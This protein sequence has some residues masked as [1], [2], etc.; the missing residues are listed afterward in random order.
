[1]ASL[2][3][4]ADALARVLDGVEP[5][6]SVDAPLT[7]AEGRVLAADVAALR[8]QPP[9]DMSAMDGY[10]ARA[11]DLTSVPIT[12]KVA[13]EVAAGHPFRGELRPGEVARIFTGGVVPP[14]ADTIVI[15]ENTSRDGDRVTVRQ[16]EKSGRHIRRAGLDFKEGQVLLPRGRRLT[17]R[18]VM[19]AAGMSH[20]ALPVHRRPKVA[21]FATGDELKAP[22]ST[23]G[24]GE[25][26][27]SNGFG[28][29]ALARNEGVEVIDLGIVPDDVEATVAAIRR[30]RQANVDVLVTTG[31]ASVGDHDLVQRGL[32]AEGLELSFWRVA[33]RPG[34][35]IMH[36]RLGGMHVLGMPG[37][38]VSAYV[39]SFLFLVPLV[40][41][42]SG[43]SDLSAVPDSAV[44]GVDMPE[45]DERADYMRATL[46]PSSTGTPVAT[47]VKIQDSSM[48][49]ALAKADCLVVREPFEPAAKAGDRC[50]ILRLTRP[51]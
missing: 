28:L 3:L 30:A 29:M 46:A 47:P 14:G 9:A 5:L 24:P 6:P 26:I 33:L 45:N 49:V 39:C 37:N 42:L 31:G 10:A 51:F 20:P 32:K 8:T 17:D 25:I 18:D 35:P 36:G 4:V 40:R 2:L 41:R 1:M 34:R 27:Y 50:V 16:P 44:L 15:Q 48:M 38:P 22:G 7:D 43:R 13:G 21:V 12:L 11:A 23:L 19:L